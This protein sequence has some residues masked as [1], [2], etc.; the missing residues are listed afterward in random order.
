MSLR[1][2]E[3]F[4]LQPNFVDAYKGASQA[5]RQLAQENIRLAEFYDEQARKLSQ[6]LRNSS[7]EVSE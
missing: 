3:A 5:L 1:K 2:R 7:Q 4:S 6:D